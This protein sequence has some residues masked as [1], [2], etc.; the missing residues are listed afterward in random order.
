MRQLAAI[1]A[2]L[3]AT[4]A[5]PACAQPAPQAPPA[6]TATD[7]TTTDAD[8]ALW[9]VKDDDTTIYLFG[10]IHVLKPGL[11]WF[12]EAV[13]TAFDASQQLV[14]EMVEPEAGTQQQLV[15]AKGMT[16]A[17]TPGLS[18]QL[19]EAN[20]AAY[21]K[22]V[23]DLGLPATALDRMRPWLAGV[24]LTMMPLQKLGYDPNSGAEKILTSAATTAGK[25]VTGLETMEQQLGFFDSLSQPAQ[26]K[27]LTS[28][29]DELP[30]LGTIMATMI[31][32]WSKGD[33]D[34]LAR[35]INENM[36]DSPE[37]AKRLLTDRN[38]R[39]ADWLATRMK[40]PGTVFVAVGA[41]H[42][43]GEGSVQAMLGKHK[44]KAVR[45]A[46]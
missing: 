12:D 17:D 31:T 7:A 20:R 2:A 21:T 5:L 8:P 6:A 23:T 35:L 45:V 41:G 43:A 3:F 9:V 13:K 42:Q 37:V 39:W 36:K 44:L 26:I 32:D 4:V 16:A 10:T 34:A 30:K 38:A 29:V 40:T 15:M 24:T 1:A 33:P 46:Y 19:P 18:Q 25:P 11:T 28:T 22:A 27:F 14:L